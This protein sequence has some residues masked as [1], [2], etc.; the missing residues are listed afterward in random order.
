MKVALEVT[1]SGF[2]AVSVIIVSP[3]SELAAIKEST[4]KTRLAESKVTYDGN[5]AIE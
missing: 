5:P 1:D 4:V 2:V 3:E